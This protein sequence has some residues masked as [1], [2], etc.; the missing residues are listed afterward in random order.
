[1]LRRVGVDAAE[2]AV[3]SGGVVEADLGLEAEAEAARGRVADAVQA[4]G[5]T[6]VIATDPI[7]VTG[8]R[9]AQAAGKVEAGIRV[10][11]LSQALAATPIT[12]AAME[13]TTAVFHDP[14]WLSRAL[15]AAATV[16]NVLGRIEGLDLREPINS[17]RRAHS[18]G[19]LA[20]YPDPRLAREIAERRLE[21]LLW[22]NAATVL[23]A[24]PYSLA[25]LSAVAA[26]VP[27]VDLAVFLDSV[28]GPR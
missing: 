21:E 19:P 15:D 25:N 20:G 5:A 1:M 26:D 4:T 16:R 17:G 24:S 8:L 2:L 11:H 13:P 14:G 9:W 3:S 12:F 28:G 18:D 27:V 23:T 7:L 10:E 22:T 6:R